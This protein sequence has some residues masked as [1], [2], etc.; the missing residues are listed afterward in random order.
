MASNDVYNV[1]KRNGIIHN[2]INN[3]EIKS[4][5][6]NV[7]KNEMKKLKV[8]SNLI[9]ACQTQQESNVLEDVILLSDDEL[10]NGNVQSK[11]YTRRNLEHNAKIQNKSTNLEIIQFNNDNANS[12]NAKCEFGNLERSVG[13]KD[14]KYN[15]VN[16]VVDVV[17]QNLLDVAIIRN[18]SINVESKCSLTDKREFEPKCKIECNHSN[19][20]RVLPFIKSNVCIHPAENKSELEQEMELYEAFERNEEARLIHRNPHNLMR[21]EST[22]TIETQ[23]KKKRALEGY[24]YERK[25]KRNKREQKF[26]TKT[27]NEED[28]CFICF[29]GGDLILCDHRYY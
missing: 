7:G 16:N 29:D 20:E 5:L 3:N 21:E 17:V 18:M 2:K 23:N 28:V 24:F 19:V 27:K 26:V 8:D 10:P 11:Y 14:N 25:K 4:Q 13:C 9:S 15:I 22:I 6:N 12:E 1:Y